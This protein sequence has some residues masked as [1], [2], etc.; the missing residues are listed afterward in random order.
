VTKTET[1]D[2]IAAMLADAARDESPAIVRLAEMMATHM[3]EQT[4]LVQQLAA[5]TATRMQEEARENRALLRDALLG[6]LVIFDTKAARVHA[7]LST[8]RFSTGTAAA[9]AKSSPGGAGPATSDD[10]GEDAVELS[11]EEIIGDLNPLAARG[12]RGFVPPR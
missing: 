2:K 8:G 11:E 9:P 12:G 7:S 6:K 5:D 4:K 1:A 3:L 10:G